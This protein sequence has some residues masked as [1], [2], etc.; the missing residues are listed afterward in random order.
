MNEPWLIFINLIVS[1]IV[2]GV[3]ALFFYK[4]NKETDQDFEYRKHII[5]KRKPV[6][7]LVE[8]IIS[9]FTISRPIHFDSDEKRPAE[10]LI[11]PG[12]IFDGTV[13]E[14][15]DFNDKVLAVLNKGFWISDELYKELSTANEYIVKTLNDLN[16]TKS[17]FDVCRA[18]PYEGFFKAIGKK[19]ADIYFYDIC[20]LNDIEIFKKKKLYTD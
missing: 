3:V 1:A 12:F 9:G 7:D 15:E 13:E 5:E 18:V 11:V 20:N 10:V 17:D 6:Y 16:F 19:I 14:I 8:E 4:R 2:S